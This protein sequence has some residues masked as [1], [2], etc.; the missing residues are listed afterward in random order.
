[1]V[2]VTN[3]TRQTTIARQCVLGVS[4]AWRLR[5]L[6]FRRGFGPF[7]GLWRAPTAEIHMF[8]VRFPIDLVWLDDS[9]CVVAVTA[10]IRPWR[11][12]RCARASSVIELP[13]GA[14]AASATQPGDRVSF[15]AAPG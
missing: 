5:G 1:M 3:L 7:D 9:L 14:L 12:T 15:A 11:M 13:V 8:W 2:Q 4:F 10:A 6:M